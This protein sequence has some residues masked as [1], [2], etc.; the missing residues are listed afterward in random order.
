MTRNPF[1]RHTSIL[2]LVLIFRTS[3]ETLTKLAEV[4]IFAV[5]ALQSITN[6]VQAKNVASP[7]NEASG[8]TLREI[9]EATPL[10]SPPH[11]SSSNTSSKELIT[12]GNTLDD[13]DLPGVEDFCIFVVL[14]LSCTIIHPLLYSNA[15]NP[16]TVQR[17]KN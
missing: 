8:T 4:T 9:R 11:I 17:F 5:D 3:P 16:M 13:D 7:S 15:D 10:W 14:P 6:P 2:K 1:L 12:R